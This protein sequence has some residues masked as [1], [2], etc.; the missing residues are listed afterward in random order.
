[1]L[2]FLAG[3]LLVVSAI[4]VAAAPSGRGRRLVSVGSVLLGLGGVW[5]TS[6]RAAFNLTGPDGCGR[7]WR[8]SARPLTSRPRRQAPRPEPAFPDYGAVG[9]MP[10]RS[11][12]PGVASSLFGLTPS[13]GRV[14]VCDTR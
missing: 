14:K 11:D 2:L 3:A 13:G 10:G 8:C 9:A 5:L 12:C 7:A 4:G 1:V 6:G